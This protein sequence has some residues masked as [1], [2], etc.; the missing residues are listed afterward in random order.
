[1][2][3]ELLHTPRIIFGS[4]TLE[5]IGRLCRDFGS[6]L[7]VVASESVLKKRKIQELLDD[8][9]APQS[10]DYT[11][12]IIKGE[13]EVKLID[14]GVIEGK[15]FNADM[16]VGIGGGSVIDAGKAIAGLITNGE[17]ARDY[18]EVIGKG[19]QITRPSLPYIAAP[20][21]A[22]T[23]SE[24]TKNAV[25]SAKAAGLKASIRSPLL[26]PKIA[27]I[28]ISL[29][30]SVPSDV[31]ARTGLDALS[32]LI[33]AYTSK[34]S[35]PITDA[36]ALLGV[37]KA[38]HSLLKAYKNGGDIEA[39]EDMAMA[40]LLS[41]IC[42]ANAGLGA[43]HGFAGPIGGLFSI[44]HGTVCAA[45]LVPTI[46]YNIEELKEKNPNHPTLAKYAKLG[47]LCFGQTFSSG[48]EAQLA[49]IEYLRGLVQSL[50]IPKLSQFGLTNADI[51]GI[52]SK[53]KK[54]SSMRYNPIE[55]KDYT[56]YK[57]LD[58]VL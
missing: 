35:Q 25:I 31:T 41:G 42:L 55:L 10:I 2:H 32:Q 15:N 44:P 57:I 14:Q 37:Q 9:L 7:L 43:I 19:S 39:R 46:Q 8:A 21:T 24:V 40:A 5:N 17:S 47:A 11:H 20:T 56:L 1:M 53:A 48:E 45:L 22:G 36:L 18:M 3:F 38:S 58:Q 28:D 6:R 49:L 29:M 34:N 13:P 51:S 30:L 50:K 16:V 27:I 26:V 23:G 12:F 33:E 52:I 4:G 54:A